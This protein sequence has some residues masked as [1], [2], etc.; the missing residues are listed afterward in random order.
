MSEVLTLQKEDLFTSFHDSIPQ[1]GEACFH[2]LLSN[3]LKAKPS[4]TISNGTSENPNSRPSTSKLNESA[5]LTP[6]K[7]SASDKSDQLAINLTN[8]KTASTSK[9]PFLPEK[10]QHHKDK[11]TLVLDLDETLVH[12]SST[13]LPNPDHVIELSSRMKLHVLERPFLNEFLE[14]MSAIY[15]LVI[16]T[17]GDKEYA[18]AVVEKIDPRGRISHILHREH[19]VP[20]K[21]GELGKDLSLL[22]RDLKHV[23]FIDNLEANF[24]RQKDNGLKITDFYSDKSDD[25][26]KSLIPFLEY[27]SELDNVRPIW[28]VYHNYTFKGIGKAHK[29][30]DKLDSLVGNPVQEINNSHCYT[31]ETKKES[32]SNE[33]DKSEV[34]LSKFSLE[35]EDHVKPS[36]LN[37]SCMTTTTAT[38]VSKTCPSKIH[39][40]SEDSFSIANEV[41][42]KSTGKS[43][44]LD[45]IYARILALEQKLKSKTYSDLDSAK[46]D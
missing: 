23:I 45:D 31:P 17:A 38:P 11:K 18:F 9:A 41:S 14:S 22:G 30:K 19:C 39:D 46:I 43:A 16:Y 44:L 12:A 34:K 10:A 25:E 42:D 6:T 7:P 13:P 35:S 32:K 15:E 24:R 1:S 5:N 40:G 8:S 21:T 27:T 28:K 3:S 37:L 29:L 2:Q 20:N 33:D 36:K 26:L 4:N